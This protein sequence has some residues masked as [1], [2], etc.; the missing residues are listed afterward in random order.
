MSRI[1]IVSLGDDWGSE[2]IDIVMYGNVTTVILLIYNLWHKWN[3]RLSS[4]Y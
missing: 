2:I 3:I 4:E 1:I